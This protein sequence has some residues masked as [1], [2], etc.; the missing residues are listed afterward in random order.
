M[1]PYLLA[2]AGGYLIG[3]AT[4]DKQLFAKGGMY[5][6]GGGVG[7]E[8]AMAKGGIVVTKIKS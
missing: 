5:A 2:I 6:K 7:E 1:I 8:D 4:K 3:N